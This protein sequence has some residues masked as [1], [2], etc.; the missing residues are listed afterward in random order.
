[1]P[2]LVPLI[3]IAIGLAA[4]VQ[5][6]RATRAGARAAAAESASMT[7]SAIAHVLQEELDGHVLALRRMGRRW[8]ASGGLPQEIWERD[9]RRC[10]EDMP[11][12]L[13]IEFAADGR[14][15][16]WSA[17]TEGRRPDAAT[18]GL[19]LALAMAR[20]R[21]GEF[22]LPAPVP[23]GGDAGFILYQPID[24]EGAAG[25]GILAFHS[26]REF[27]E[28]VDRELSLGYG[29][30]VSV[31]G[32]AS[33]RCGE[34]M[35]PDS[36]AYARYVPLELPGVQVDLTV[37]P[38]LDLLRSGALRSRWVVLVGGAGLAFLLGLTVLLAL[39]ERGRAAALA[40]VMRV[41]EREAEER[42]RVMRSLER[43]EARA[44]HL[45]EL[46]PDGMLIVDSEGRIEM[47]NAR[48]VD[49]FGYSPAELRGQPIEVLIPD[50][51]RER[52]RAHRD[53]YLK[54]PRLRVMGTD[55]SLK[56]RRKDGSEFPVEVS[57][58]PWEGDDGLRATAAI[59]DVS[60]RDKLRERSLESERRFAG[61]A[62]T[63][64]DVFWMLDAGER[65]V[66]F[67]SPAYEKIWG[68]SIEH[69]YENPEDWNDGIHPDDRDR[70]VRVSASATTVGYD[71]RFR[72][73][74]PDGSMRWVHDRG[75]PVH[76]ED[77]NLR[78]I[79]GIA[80][81]ITQAREADEKLE[82]R[83][84]ELTALEVLGR[85][86]QASLSPAEVVR[87]A[88]EEIMAPVA[89][90]VSLLLLRE[91]EDLVLK[92]VGPG[93][94]S[95]F[96]DDMAMHHVGECLCGLAAT[97]EGPTYSSNMNS[98]PR[99]SREECIEAG[100]VSFAALPMKGP[101]G[102]LG[103]IG[104][105]S[106]TARDFA[107]QSTF[108]EAAADAVGLALRNAILHE[109]VA[110]HGEELEGRV[111]RRTAQ[112]S[113]AK[114]QAEEADRLKSVF[115]AAMSH[116][117]RTP[118]NSIIGFTGILLQELAG[119]LNAEQ[120]KQL[121]MVKGSA[122]HLLGLIN[123]ILDISKIE[124]GQLELAI[125]EFSLRESVDLVVR[126]MAPLAE[127][128]GLSLTVSGELPETPIRSDRRRVEQ[129]LLNLL[130]NAVKFTD[131]GDVRVECAAKEGAVD[132]RVVDTGIGIR[133]ED[134]KHLFESFRQLEGGLSRP[135]DGTGLGLA[136]TRRLIDALGGTVSVESVIY[137]GST[138]S[139]HL[140]TTGSS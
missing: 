105:G 11:G 44:L 119:P 22:A 81:D 19:N 7:A 128:K 1:M 96:H 123:D 53:R 51:L 68:R 47:S 30:T 39:V 80:Q 17:W 35:D 101:S 73:V 88:L 103:V 72:V 21:D 114:E 6:W 65:R 98:D 112:L 113:V 93:H 40:R 122:R 23:P 20:E 89:P 8:E 66:L 29:L 87:I 27:V 46:A 136:I 115:L 49:L 91:G 118:L 85:R 124:A 4:T 28:V 110:R 63:I 74:R 99:C 140:P 76:D 109:E 58:S 33:F 45:F 37:W 5:V 97:I 139:I 32:E 52:H 69:L 132:L 83:M 60:E 54:A 95:E 56:A 133:E 84:A 55:Q 100:M 104:I 127:E 92:G 129:I 2:R 16:P 121:G 62:D 82:K 34:D 36:R 48:S 67:V 50:G 137:E 41:R 38:D 108:L 18:E 78:R 75:L 15:S 125:E 79:A 135:H 57:L 3:V 24:G 12:L 138:F 64:E 42:R 90:D 70:V 111:A 116:E 59:R 130:S 120:S 107:E 43:S 31:D 26:W 102:L 9:A 134:K 14:E 71:V 94:D 25:A 10:V 126:S 77:G 13:G 117:L 61:I 131:E 106:S 86:V